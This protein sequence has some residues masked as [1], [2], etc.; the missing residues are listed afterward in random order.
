M[1][2]HPYDLVIERPTFACSTLRPASAGLNSSTPRPRRSGNGWPTCASNIP[3]PAWAYARPYDSS[4]RRATF[5]PLFLH[6]YNFHRPHSALHSLPP[7]S[8]LPITADN[9]SRYNS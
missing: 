1:T 2:A 7:A 5:L 4:D 6:D 3:P 8:R 9:V